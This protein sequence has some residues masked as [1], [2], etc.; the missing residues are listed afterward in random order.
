M[1]EDQE[2]KDEPGTPS[3][4]GHLQHSAESDGRTS[5]RSTRAGVRHRLSGVK[6]RHL[7]LGGAVGLGLLGH[8]PR[9]FPYRTA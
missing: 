5:D 4:S 9:L 1:N 6:L 3:D 8:C 2:A 7:T